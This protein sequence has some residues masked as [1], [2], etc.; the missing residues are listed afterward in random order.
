MSSVEEGNFNFFD[1][2][3]DDIVVSI[4]CKLSSA[5]ACPWE[6]IKILLM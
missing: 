3:P 6:L 4:L 2:L 1:R 5:A